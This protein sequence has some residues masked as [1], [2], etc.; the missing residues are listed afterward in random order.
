MAEYTVE[1]RWLHGTCH[2]PKEGTGS[3]Y[4]LWFPKLWKGYVG[5]TMRS[6]KQRYADHLSVA[7]R[8]VTKCPVHS[9]IRELGAPE[10][11]VLEQLQDR[12]SL[13]AAERR[14]VEELGT[15]I[16][17]GLN[18]TVGG[19]GATGIEVLRAVTDGRTASFPVGL[20]PGGWE[21]AN[22]GKAPYR[23]R[24]TGEVAM[25]PVGTAP[26]GWEH[27]TK[28]R[29]PCKNLVTGETAQFQ[30]GSVPDGWVPVTK[31]M[32]SCRNRSTGGTSSFPVDA[33]PPGWEHITKG[34]TPCRNLVT[35][36]TAQFVAGEIPEGWGGTGTGR[37]SCQNT[38][39]GETRSFLVG[40]IP[41]GWETVSLA[42]WRD[43]SV[44]KARLTRHSV[45]VNDTVYKSFRRA[46][47]AL[48]L[49][50]AGHT[51]AIA[52]CKRDGSVEFQGYE[53]VLVEKRPRSAV[54][55]D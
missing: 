12:A 30:V 46:M 41:D 23:D 49:S 25:F 50:E 44:R 36:E 2:E 8:R 9:A 18:G 13:H 29:V 53:F 19:Q 5:A 14:W 24:V 28:G 37:V 40:G 3:V 20:R 42:S 39:T 21:A 22:A 10:I 11:F 35:G 16:P 1:I 31:G 27:I 51:S 48:G 47:T 38:Q 17:N 15:F 55:G 45:R 32:V 52:K 6:V 26:E 4:L 33:V 43:P 34:M 7:S 54:G